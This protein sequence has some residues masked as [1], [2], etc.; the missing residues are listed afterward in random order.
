MLIDPDSTSFKVGLIF[1]AIVQLT[2][3]GV[4][5]WG[6]VKIVLKFTS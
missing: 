1:G 3:V 4:I 6:I 5:I 2:F